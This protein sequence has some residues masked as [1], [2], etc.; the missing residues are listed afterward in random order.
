MLRQKAEKKLFTFM[1]LCNKYTTIQAE[2]EKNDPL[3]ISKQGK[4]IDDSP[5]KSTNDSL[6]HSPQKITQQEIVEG[7]NNQT[8]EVTKKQQ[9]AVGQNRKRTHSEAFGK[10]TDFCTMVTKQSKC[11]INMQLS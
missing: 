5:T 11:S 9:K 6:N 7:V 3:Q 4:A 10:T 2:Q 8:L 1:K